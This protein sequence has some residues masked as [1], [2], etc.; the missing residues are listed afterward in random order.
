MHI[1]RHTA[2]KG[3]CMKMWT[4]LV[5]VVCCGVVVSSAIGGYAAPRSNGLSYNSLGHNGLGKSDVLNDRAVQPLTAPQ[6]EPPS[7]RM[8]RQVEL[9]NPELASTAVKRQQLTYLVQCALPEDVA[10]YTDQ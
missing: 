4:T 9:A 2:T 8:P 7:A 5:L 1:P 10:L 3:H 6:A